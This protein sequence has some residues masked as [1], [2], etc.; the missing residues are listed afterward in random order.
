M[1]YGTYYA[2]FIIFHQNRIMIAIDSYFL[3]YIFYKV[4][5]THPT[6]SHEYHMKTY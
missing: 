2:P 6:L 3:L 1:K 5:N 4:R